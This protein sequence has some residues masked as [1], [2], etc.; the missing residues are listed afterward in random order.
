MSSGLVTRK[1]CLVIGRVMPRMSASWKASVP[2]AWEFTWPVMA[3]IGT[4]SMYASASPV[5]RFVAPGPEVAM[6]T[7]TRPV[8]IAYPSA[9]WAAPCSCR[10]RMWRMLESNSGSYAG[11]IAPPGIPKTTSA[12]RLSSDLTSAWAP[13]T[14]V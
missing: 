1:L 14:W 8:T 13:V 12:P 10:T 11:R 4:E 3:T 5:T 2:I 7:P 6:Q 9:A